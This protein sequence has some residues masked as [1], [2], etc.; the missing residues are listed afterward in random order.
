MA[1]TVSGGTSSRG[2]IPPGSL[3]T[4]DD[5]PLPTELIGDLVDQLDGV[6]VGGGGE[7][8]P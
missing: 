2:K 6:G 3:T 4:V 8:V 7:T 5:V 1:A